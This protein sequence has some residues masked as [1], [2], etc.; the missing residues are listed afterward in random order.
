M[1]LIDLHSPDKDFESV[2][3]LGMRNNRNVSQSYTGDRRKKISDQ[4]QVL[5]DMDEEEERQKQQIA[6]QKGLGSSR[7]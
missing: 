6:L 5:I 2:I 3:M 4:M 7:H 1:S